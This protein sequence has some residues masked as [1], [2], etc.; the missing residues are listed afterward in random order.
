MAK[1]EWNIEE[2]EELLNS[3]RK[4]AHNSKGKK[5]NKKRRKMRDDEEDGDVDSDEANYSSKVF[6]RYIILLYF[7]IIQ[8]FIHF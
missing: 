8:K 2:A 1:C 6:D 7:Q 5:R 3:R 4:R